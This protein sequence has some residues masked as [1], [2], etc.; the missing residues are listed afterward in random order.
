VIYF[1]HNFENYEALNGNELLTIFIV[2]LLKV[3]SEGETESKAKKYMQEC[4][5]CV[6]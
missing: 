6:L 3:I 1:V 4:R 5:R 2:K